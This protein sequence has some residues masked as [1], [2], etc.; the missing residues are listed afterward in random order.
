MLSLGMM[1]TSC[2][3]QKALTAQKMAQVQI[4]M[5]KAEVETLL[6]SPVLCDGN[7]ISEKWSYK[8]TIYGSDGPRD[9]MFVVTFNRITKGV[10]SYEN[11]PVPKMGKHHS[12]DD[13]G[14]DRNE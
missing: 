3:S 2:S 8:H 4:G 5:S 13:S 7:L 1:M 14:D 9:M 6:G 11:I 12:K 10:V